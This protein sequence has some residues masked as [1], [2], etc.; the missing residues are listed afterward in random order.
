VW[1]PLFDEGIVTSDLAYLC[2]PLPSKVDFFYS[3]VATNLAC[4]EV[5][6]YDPNPLEIV[7]VLY[8]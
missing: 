3:S 1:L 7:F 4:V 8:F 2:I 6:V 5:K